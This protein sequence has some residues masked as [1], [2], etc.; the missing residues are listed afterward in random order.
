MKHQTKIKLNKKALREFRFEVN[1]ERFYI[2]P[3]YFTWGA[4][5]MWWSEFGFAWLIFDFRY[6]GKRKKEEES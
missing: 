4:K 6:M 1:T 2:L 5:F 3:T